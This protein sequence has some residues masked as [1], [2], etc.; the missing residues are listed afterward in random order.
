LPSTIPLQQL[1]PKR[2]A[3]IAVHACATSPATVA[4]SNTASAIRCIASR[5]R[6]RIQRA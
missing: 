1:D 2:L 6:A 4:A 5:T 3:Y